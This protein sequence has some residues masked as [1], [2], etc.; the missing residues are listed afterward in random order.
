MQQSHEREAAPSQVRAQGGASHIESKPNSKPDAGRIGF[1]RDNPDH[2]FWWYRFYYGKY[3][4]ITYAL[5]SDDEVGVI[6]DWYE[7]VTARKIFGETGP[8]LVS[9]M[10]SFITSSNL[11]RVVQCGHYAG[12]STLMLG[13]I[14]RRM[15]HTNALFTVD[16]NARMSEFTR[17]WVERAGLGEVVRVH[18]GDSAD[19]ATARA[20]AQYLRGAPQALLIDSSHQYEHTLRELDLWFEAMT[21]GGL[22]FLHDV[23]DLAMQ[24]DSTHRGG[25]RR[26]LGEWLERNKV[27][28]IRI[29]DI[30]HMDPKAACYADG[31][32]LG[33]IQKPHAP[34]V[35]AAKKFAALTTA[36][37]EQWD[38]HD[39]P[40]FAA[41][42]GS[43]NA[44]ILGFRFSGE[45]GRPTV[46]LDPGMRVRLE[47]AIHVEEPLEDLVCGLIVNE[48]PN[49]LFEENTLRTHASGFALDSPGT[50]IV[51]LELDWPEMPAGRWPVTLGLGQ[52]ANPDRHN[53]LCWANQ[54][55]RI[56]VKSAG[57]SGEARL[58]LRFLGT[59][60]LPQHR[61]S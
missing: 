4:P 44:V 23:S 46:L 59:R 20:A 47:L 13:F 42:T 2:R 31:C 6:R 1:L 32:G 8:P 56:E 26:A 58:G 7:D 61:L 10:Q 12:F 22:I 37:R 30:A 25:V 54:A 41:L 57:S 36:L 35:E 48:G 11:R 29:N 3:E 33:I 28:C 18:V 49:R 5:L 43:L 39:Q 34:R 17:S 50:H 19:P 16:I 15:G 9:I 21:P 40:P 14:L 53:I 45:D 38:Q 52:G 55:V 60:T 27:E 24:W 51:N